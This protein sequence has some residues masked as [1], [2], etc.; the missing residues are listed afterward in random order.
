MFDDVVSIAL[1]GQPIPENPGVRKT[2]EV[3]ELPRSFLAGPE[4]RLALAAVRAVLANKHP[5]YNPVVF[6]GP[7]GTGKSHLAHGLARACGGRRRR[8][9]SL[10]CTTAADFARALVDAIE[11]QAMDDFRSRYRQASLLVVE[12]VS[13]LAGKEAAQRE[14]LYTVDAMVAAGRWMVVTSRMAPGQMQEML[15]G[16]RYRL[17]AGLTVPLAP[18]GP[19]ARLAILRE[20]AAARG[21]DMPAAVIRILADGMNGTVPELLGALMELEMW[22]QMEAS[23]VDTEAA[24]RYLTQRDGA[25]Q[26][27]LKRIALLTARSFSL[28][29]ADLRSSSRRR[30]VVTARGV[31]MYLAR[32]LTHNSLQQIGRYFGGR[33]H[34]TVLHGC[35]QM[36]R[37]L[38][39]EPTIQETVEQLRTKL[40]IV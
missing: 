32:Q 9:D 18:P 13:H 29:V 16:L 10:I 23:T 39:T 28:K 38:R 1:Q 36:E 19:D 33:D 34:T 6:Y 27:A 37:R 20:L 25:H 24:R 21:L 4:N 5:E 26:P 11:T 30:A 15:P 2:P 31:A 8:R 14:L 40:G 3:L 7:S 22:E 12:D 17:T 35:R